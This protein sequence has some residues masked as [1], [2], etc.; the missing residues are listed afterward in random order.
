MSKS[1]HIGVI[2]GTLWGNRGAE[3][4]L[5]TTIGEVRERI[6]G[7]KFVIFSYYP[8]EDA[9]LLNDSS[10]SVVSL[11]PIELALRDLPLALL[12]KIASIFS[13]SIPSRLL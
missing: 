10:I 8:S 13:I 11:K 4:M 12:C 1:A 9:K 2:S 7:A 6:P 5:V 3:A